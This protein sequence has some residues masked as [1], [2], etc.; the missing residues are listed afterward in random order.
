MKWNFYSPEDD[1]TR[2]VYST[3]QRVGAECGGVG[4]GTSLSTITIKPE[5]TEDSYRAMLTEHKK[6]RARKDVSLV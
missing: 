6:R 1:Q 2:P 5:L 4:V 3:H